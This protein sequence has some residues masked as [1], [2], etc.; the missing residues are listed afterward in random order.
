MLENPEGAKK[1]GLTL[2]FIFPK[3]RVGEMDGRQAINEKAP[4]FVNFPIS[5]IFYKV[6]KEIV[7]L[8]HRHRLKY[9]VID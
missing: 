8:A 2:L 1:K 5:L 6:F 4:I 9:K 3:I 7:T